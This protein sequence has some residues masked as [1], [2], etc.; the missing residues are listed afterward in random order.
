MARLILPLL[1]VGAGAYYAHS[2]GLIDLSGV[3][4]FVPASLWPTQAVEGGRTTVQ[5]STPPTAPEAVVPASLSAN[6]A[7]PWAPSPQREQQLLWDHWGEVSGWSQA[8]PNKT[9]ALMWQ[10][11]RGRA[12][13]V[14]P[15]GALGLMQVM[16]ATA[17]DIYDRLGF[18]KYEI[19]RA[20]MLRPEVSIYL[21]TAY[22]DWLDSI[23]PMRSQPQRDEWLFR[24]YNGGSGNALHRMNGGT[25]GAASDREND[26][27]WRAVTA[28]YQSYSEV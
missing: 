9:A 17:H 7:P 6:S 23:N 26:N 13:A 2:E 28:R 1:V 16:P 5:P 20:N 3:K 25:V 8:N 24:A 27:Y 22:L 4:D 10:E 11:S 21:G 15:A 19:T 18:Q 14:S 12:G